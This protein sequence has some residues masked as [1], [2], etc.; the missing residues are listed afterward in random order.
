MTNNDL[1]TIHIK[2]KIEK[3]E[4]NYKPGVNLGS[5]EG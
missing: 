3:H 5:P 1:Q 4:P 2:Q